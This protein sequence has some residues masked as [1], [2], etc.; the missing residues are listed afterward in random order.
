MSAPAA[1]LVLLQSR[2]GVCPYADRRFSLYWGTE[3]LEGTRGS[4]EL[5]RF[6]WVT[7]TRSGLTHVLVFGGISSD[8]LCNRESQQH[9]ENQDDS[10]GQQRA[11]FPIADDPSAHVRFLALGQKHSNGSLNLRAVSGGDEHLD[12]R[13]LSVPEHKTDRCLAICCWMSQTI[14]CYCERSTRE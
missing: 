7:F 1:S 14:L 8:H 4:R 3:T 9:H 13:P 2:T 6:G 11:E 10:A 5:W 12:T